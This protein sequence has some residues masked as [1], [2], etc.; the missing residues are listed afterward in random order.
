MQWKKKK[1]SVKTVKMPTVM[2]EASSETL[3]DGRRSSE[4]QEQG[5]QQGEQSLHPS[6]LSPA[7]PDLRSINSRDLN[8]VVQV[9]LSERRIRFLPF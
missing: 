7:L 5:R 6:S 9:L 1:K 2:K 4:G 8:L 3:H